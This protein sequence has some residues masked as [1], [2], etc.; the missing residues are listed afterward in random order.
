MVVHEQIRASCVSA[1]WELVHVV[2]LCD[3][4]AAVHII[5]VVVVHVQI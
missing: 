2:A 4:A 3:M 1:T 5:V